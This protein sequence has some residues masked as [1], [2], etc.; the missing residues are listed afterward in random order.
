VETALRHDERVQPPAR[1]PDGQPPR[2][3]AI[4]LLE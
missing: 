3:F 4:I 1:S 2:P